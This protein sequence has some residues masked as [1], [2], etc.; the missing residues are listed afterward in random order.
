MKNG[1]E[2][3]MGERW[4]ETGRKKK[5]VNGGERKI[6]WQYVKVQGRNEKEYG[7]ERRNGKERGK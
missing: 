7:I 3:K 5:G 1:G 6:D 2:R 4:K